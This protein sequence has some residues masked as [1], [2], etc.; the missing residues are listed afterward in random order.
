VTHAKAALNEPERE[1]P[2]LGMHVLAPGEEMSLD[3]RLDVIA[4]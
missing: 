1:W 4:K 2:G 3:M